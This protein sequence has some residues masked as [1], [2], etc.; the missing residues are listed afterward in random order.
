MPLEPWGVGLLVKEVGETEKRPDLIFL[1]KI[2]GWRILAHLEILKFD[3]MLNDES[4]E[5]LTT[6]SPYQFSMWQPKL[7]K[8]R[9]QVTKRGTITMVLPYQWLYIHTSLTCL[10]LVT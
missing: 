9:F 8:V 10:S 5:V 6:V 4:D 2:A 3:F 1:L 7:D